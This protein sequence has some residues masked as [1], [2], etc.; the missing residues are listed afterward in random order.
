[1]DSTQDFDSIKQAL[2][3]EDITVV[4]NAILSLGAVER[5]RNQATKEAEASEASENPLSRFMNRGKDEVAPAAPHTLA[6]F[7]GREIGECQDS[8]R[9]KISTLDAAFRRHRAALSH[10]VLCELVFLGL[11]ENIYLNF[12]VVNLALQEITLRGDLTSQ[13]KVAEIFDT[14]C[15]YYDAGHRLEEGTVQDLLLDGYFPRFQPQVQAGLLLKAQTDALQYDRMDAMFAPALNGLH[16]VSVLEPVLA[17]LVEYL[18]QCS[19]AL[20]EDEEGLFA[21]ELLKALKLPTMKHPSLESYIE[22]LQELLSA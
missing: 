2:A 3:S 22:Q 11:A 20:D 16:D 6:H 21:G 5:N 9:I 4:S 18:T 10:E 7:A 1:M 12:N 17:K 14:A 13:M 19:D 15:T 8:E